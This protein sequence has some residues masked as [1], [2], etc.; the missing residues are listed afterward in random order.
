[1]SLK[2]ETCWVSLHMFRFSKGNRV[3]F[4]QFSIMKEGMGSAII[5]C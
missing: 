5:G 1:M 3:D 2:S 4:H